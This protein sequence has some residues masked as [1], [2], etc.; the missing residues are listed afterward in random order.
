MRSDWVRYPPPMSQLTANEIGLAISYMDNSK[1]AHFRDW[2]EEGVSIF[3]CISSVFVVILM[4]TRLWQED[5]RKVR[6]GFFEGPVKA[7]D[8]VKSAECSYE[9]LKA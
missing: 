6:C 4:H 7:L 9:L 8:I 5:L 3:S 2:T 1:Q